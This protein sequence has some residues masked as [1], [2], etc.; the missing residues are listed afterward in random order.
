MQ[1]KVNDI[2]NNLLSELPPC[3]K[4][5]IKQLEANEDIKLKTLLL[6]QLMNFLMFKTNSIVF[7]K[8]Y[9]VAFNEKF[10]PLVSLSIIN[11]ICMNFDYKNPTY[12]C[13][14]PHLR[15]NCNKDLC[16]QLDCGLIKLKNNSR[17][18]LKD[19]KKYVPLGKDGKTVS[20][21]ITYSIIV[22]EIKITIND[23]NSLLNYKTFSKIVAETVNKP[24]YPISNQDWHNE[25]EV[26]FQD[27]KTIEYDNNSLI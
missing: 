17:L 21:K 14:N 25:L 19:L 26:L 15:K 18:Q 5:I 9:L 20:G 7:A 22:N 12:S 4:V 13:S 1:L 16:L 3:L 11:N 23:I 10:K 27:I 8:E 6:K 2:I 24:P